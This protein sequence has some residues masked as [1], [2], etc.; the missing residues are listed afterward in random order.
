MDGDG[1]VNG[2]D[3]DKDCIMDGADNDPTVIDF[4]GPDIIYFYITKPE[5][6][7]IFRAHFRIE[8]WDHGIKWTS[9]T[10][11]SDR[12]VYRKNVKYCPTPTLE[13]VGEQVIWGCIDFHFDRIM[14]YI[15]MP[16]VC[17][18]SEDGL[19]GLNFCNK[20]LKMG[21][22]D[23]LVRGIITYIPSAALKGLLSGFVYAIG[24]SVAMS[25]NMLQS[26]GSGENIKA[27]G[28]FG[29]FI[30]KNGWGVF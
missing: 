18:A 22:I 6:T 20:A 8:D 14:D 15:L 4:S 7:L 30:N 5:K 2:K 10:I 21:G 1:W 16:V 11:N 24:E 13:T 27:M 9:I 3:S 25:A 26:I 17:I 29:E 23:Q 19:G 12:E 28:K